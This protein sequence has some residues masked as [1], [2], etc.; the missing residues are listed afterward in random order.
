MENLTVEK[1]IEK[2]SNKN[3]RKRG[4]WHHGVIFSE[5]FGLGEST[6]YSE[7]IGYP[8]K[9]STGVWLANGDYLDIQEE[10]DEMRTLIENNYAKDPQYLEKYSKHCLEKAEEIVSFC[11]KIKN[12]DVTKLSNQEL[13]DMYMDLVE[14]FK[15]FMPFMIS[16]HSID[17]I[18]TKKFN[19]ALS[20]FIKEKG[21]SQSDF[22]E[23][24]TILTFPYRKILV[25]EEQESLL[26][27]AVKIKTEKLQTTDPTIDI[28]LD[29]HVEKYSW[30]NAYLFENLPHTKE[31][32]VD[33]LKSL[34]ETN[35]EEEYILKTKAEEKIKQEQ[36]K[37]MGEILSHP[38][39]FALSKEIQVFGF[40]RS[41]RVDV[42]FY[43]FV[44]VM[45]LLNEISKRIT[46]S[47]IDIKY[48]D[49]TEVSSILNT[50]TELDYL[51]LIE[52]RKSGFVSIAINGERCELLGE[53][54]QKVSS[55][56]KIHEEVNNG[57]IKGTI[58]YPGK[59]TAHCKVLFSLE[60]MKKIEEGDVMV[61]AMTDPNYIPAMVK[62]AAFVTDQGGILCHAAIV[63]R[64]MK[65]PCII[66]TKN[67]TKV[68]KDGNMVEVDAEK[69][70]VRIIK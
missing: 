1:I 7:K 17:E 42:I 46:I 50:K 23:Y 62:A 14:E 4:N 51:T 35:V 24:Q 49:S 33:K 61:I 54:A 65:K 67:A 13:S 6:E 53:D 36:E 5:I 60:D 43:S 25:L 63:S 31:Y 38:E 32:F 40:L 70:I 30:I 55:I 52:K 69:G 29:E 10:W 15:Q 9:R 27:I 8:F 20:D 47:V 37:L 64:E 58:A 66:G 44:L 45:N 3:W 39:L 41:Y 16:V 11:K 57:A 21:L 2:L 68:L 34:L 18:L 28:L 12:Q 26:K 22:F 59:L 56:I 19:E 48:L